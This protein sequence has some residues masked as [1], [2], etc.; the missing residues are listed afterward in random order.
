MTSQVLERPAGTVEGAP[1]P[2]ASGE[3]LAVS[4]RGLT[5]RY[6]DATVVDD[7]DLE[8]PE[9]AVYGFLGPNGAGK[10]TTMKMLLG[11]VHASGGE[12]VVLGREMTPDNRLEVLREVGSLIEAPQLLPAPHGARE[13]RDRAAPARAARELHR[14]GPFGR[15]PGRREDAAEARR[16]L[17]PRH[18]AAPGHRRRAHGAPKAAAPG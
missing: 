10:S 11:L 4:T 18:E 15:A 8:V 2:A 6:G 12:A 14:R 7:M 17:L 16:T 9:G 13:P 5:K 1:A 3:S